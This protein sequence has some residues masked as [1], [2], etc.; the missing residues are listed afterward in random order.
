[1][2]GGKKSTG[3]GGLVGDIGTILGDDGGWVANCYA[4]GVVTSGEGS[5][6]IGGLVGGL[7]LGGVSN[8]F[9]DVETTG[10]TTSDGGTGKTTA[11][12]QDINT[13][14]TTGWDFIG[15]TVNGTSDIWRMSEN[16][17]YPVLN[18]FQGYTPILPVGLGTAEEPFLVNNVEELGSVVYYPLACY[19]LDSNVDLSEIVW[20]TA[21]I[22]WFGGHFDG[23][24]YV[25]SNLSVQG[26]GHLGLFGVLGENAVVTNMRIENVSIQGTGDLIGGLVGDNYGSV[27]NCYITGTVRGNNAASV[28]GLVGDNSGD[29][30]RCYSSGAV[31]GGGPVGGLIGLGSATH[32]YSTATVSGNRYV[33][34]LV[35][36]AGNVK[37]C[38]SAGEVS[39]DKYVGGLVGYNFWNRLTQCYSTGAVNGNDSVGGLVGYSQNGNIIHCY[40]TGVVSGSSNVGGLMG[41][42]ERGTVL[43]CFWDIE[44]SNQNTSAGGIGK[45]TAAMQDIRTYLDGGWDFVDE[46]GNGTHQIWQMPEGGGYPILSIFSGYTHLQLNGLGTAEDPYLIS[47]TL[48]LGAMIYYSPYAHYRLDSSIDLLGICWSTAVIPTFEGTFDGNNLTISHLTIK[49]VSN[50]G[51]FERLASGA[52]IKDLELVDVNIN[53]LG[54]SVGGLAV[55]NYG[56]VTHCCS[57]GTGAVSGKDEVGGLV[58]YNSGTMTHCYNTGSVLWSEGWAAVGGLMS[59]NDGTVTQCYSTGAVGGGSSAGGLMSHN[60]GTVT[61]CYS[62]GAVSG[63]EW[64]GGLVGFN[65]GTVIQCYSTGTVF[66]HSDVG[67][68]IGYN[69]YNGHVTNCFW[70]TQTSGQATSNEGFGKTTAEMQTADTFL[71]TGWDFVDETE[72]VTDDIWW[73]L[74]GQDYPKLWWEA[75]D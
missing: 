45:T 29:V 33:G 56:T 47:N 65:C 27:S 61:Q 17:G 12:M 31:N 43:D 46:I 16:G 10:Q 51:L 44:T 34:G 39:G 21:V 32:C 22:P 23:N 74:E 66:G 63:R 38:Y 19:R 28:G 42:N 26:G 1:V 62:T 72:N 4:T 30:T 14:L 67:G 20:S 36:F 9:W 55:Y 13:Y 49:G 2:T 58:G 50:L 37:Y 3:L 41:Q 15:E 35:G 53:G 8:S 64:V 48:E 25:L 75:S 54:G 6:F 18:I 73:I 52:E 59:V 11:Q 57:T 7:W 69:P 5:L 68:L 71:E 40:S 60:Y 24:G 70:D